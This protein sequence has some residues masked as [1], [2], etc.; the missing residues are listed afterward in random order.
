MEARVCPEAA[1]QGGLGLRLA[2]HKYASVFRWMPLEPGL[3]THKVTASVR[4]AVSPAARVV[5]TLSYL[6]EKQQ[7]IPGLTGMRYIPANW[8]GAPGDESAKHW[9]QL[10]V[11]ST[12]PAKAK[13][14]GVSLMAAYMLPGDSV[15]I[16]EVMFESR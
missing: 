10:A 6:D 7:I 1:R 2:N 3:R 8:R 16:D 13:W 12:A 11:V 4:G 14:V 5:L 9:T 15:D